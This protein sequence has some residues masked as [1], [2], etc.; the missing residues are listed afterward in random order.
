MEIIIG[1][2]L[3]FRSGPTMYELNTRGSLTWH[4]SGLEVV[5]KHT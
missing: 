2:E 3:Y 5:S 1:M 4:R